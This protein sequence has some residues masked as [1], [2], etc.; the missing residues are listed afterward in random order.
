[1]EG[2]QTMEGK[3]EIFRK[4]SLERIQSPEQLD[5]YLKVTTPMVWIILAAIL[6][7][8]AAAFWWS[9]ETE[10]ASRVETI[11]VVKD[12]VLTV[13]LEDERTRQLVKKDMDIQIGDISETIDSVQTDAAGAVKALTYVELPNGTY[14]VQISYKYTRLL[15]LLF[16]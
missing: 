6:L 10:I 16:N 14:N 4:S 2:K 9:S 11:G 7:L 8:L 12:G 3:Q 13:V 5:Q 15:S 1:M